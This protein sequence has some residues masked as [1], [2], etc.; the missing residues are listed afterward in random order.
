MKHAKMLISAVL[1]I[2]L[3]CTLTGC[4]VI[5]LH[6]Y[7]DDIDP[8]EVSSIQIYNLH[9]TATNRDTFLQA[10]IPVYAL[11]PEEHTA[12][13]NELAAIPFTDY[14]TII[15]APSDSSWRYDGWTVCIQYKDGSYRMISNGFGQGFDAGGKM[16]DGNGYDCDD[17]Q[18]EQFMQKYL[19]HDLFAP[20]SISL[21]NQVL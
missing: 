2:A 14:I 5:P 8:E 3:L 13:I 18:W 12:F 9:V 21:P 7:Y 11:S 19:P 17:S 10:E 16:I 1:L 15:L 20:T 4:I 6:D